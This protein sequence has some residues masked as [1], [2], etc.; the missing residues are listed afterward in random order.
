MYDE[1]RQPIP[2]GLQRG[3]LSKRKSIER[4]NK[5]I[6]LGNEVGEGSS[7]S[8]D[9]H[10]G[11][12]K[13]SWNKDNLTLDELQLETRA[14]PATY[15][16][17][18]KLINKECREKSIPSP[19]P[20]GIGWSF[21][22][23]KDRVYT[24][25][26]LIYLLVKLRTAEQFILN[27]K[28][29]INI[30]HVRVNEGIAKIKDLTDVVWQK[31]KK[32]ASLNPQKWIKSKTD[33]FNARMEQFKRREE[34]LK[35]QIDAHR[36]KEQQMELD[37]KKLSK[38]LA[39]TK[40]SKT[41]TDWKYQVLLNQ[42]RVLETQYSNIQ[43]RLTSK[44]KYYSNNSRA[45]F[46]M[47]QIGKIPLLDKE[48]KKQARKRKKSRQAN[49]NF[50]KNFIEEQNQNHILDLQKVISENNVLSRQR[51][52]LIE[53]L[54]DEESECSST[55]TNVSVKNKSQHRISLKGPSVFDFYYSKLED[56]FVQYVPEAVDDVTMLLESFPE[57]EHLVYTKV[58]LK[59]GITPVPQYFGVMEGIKERL[60]EASPSIHYVPNPK[61]T[62]VLSLEDDLNIQRFEKTKDFIESPVWFDDNNMDGL[63]VELD[64]GWGFAVDKFVGDR[65]FLL[66]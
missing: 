10:N 14:D 41:D 34:F 53:R 22:H 6:N 7:F 4:L 45:D 8:L 37:I 42:K 59:F 46:A 16:Y 11:K 57:N 32:I 54:D 39:S 38:D 61:E 66:N 33:A 5:I 29:V 28:E 24:V 55:L 52:Y 43:Q 18:G 51:D 64:K 65:S 26:T 21:R 44:L 56:I 31:D 62:L 63:S 20:G 1:I 3:L 58:C 25:N 27:M 49:K 17:Y 48:K 35:K 19:Y 50:I 60:S 2:E 30:L 47:K 13:A 40:K 9:I 12:R 15:S 23:T 36:K